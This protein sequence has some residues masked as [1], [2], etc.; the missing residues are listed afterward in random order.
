M[1]APADMGD[2]D[3]LAAAREHGPWGYGGEV[4]EAMH[5][6][7]WPQL[8]RIHHMAGVLAQTDRD[9]D[10]ARNGYDAM[11]LLHTPTSPLTRAA[12]AAYQAM[13]DHLVHGAPLADRPRWTAQQAAAHAGIQ[14]STWRAMVTRGQ[15]PPHLPGYDPVSG[16]RVWD[17]DV[18]RV[19][20]ATRPGRGARTAHQ[21]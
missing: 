13:W 12:D 4:R 17:A 6:R 15:A 19:W 20:Q 9:T 1:T 5:R 14:P 3:L 21:P 11:R 2:A 18:V 16:L 8:G 10:I 7:Y